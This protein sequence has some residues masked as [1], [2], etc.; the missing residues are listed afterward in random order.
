[1]LPW[2]PFCSFLS[3]NHTQAISGQEHFPP[4]ATW[5]P[6]SLPSYMASFSLESS[7]FAILTPS[8][9][10]PPQSFAVLFSVALSP[11][12]TAFIWTCVCVGALCFHNR[13]L[14]YA[15]CLKAG[16]PATPSPAPRLAPDST[17][18][19][20]NCL[21][22]IELRKATSLV[23]SASRSYVVTFLLPLKQ[24]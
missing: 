11:S 23:C 7:A 18:A 16:M 14:E 6:P 17:K 21:L 2:L 12:N 20:Q 9:P 24:E 15:G 4:A 1:M 8:S 13:Q 10:P 5:P 22:C 19:F 3:F